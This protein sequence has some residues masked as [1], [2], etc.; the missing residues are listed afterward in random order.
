MGAWAGS[1]SAIAGAMGS[2][3]I[4]N[5]TVVENFDRENMDMEKLLKGIIVEKNSGETSYSSNEPL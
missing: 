3:A 2:N 5:S 1:S 4:P